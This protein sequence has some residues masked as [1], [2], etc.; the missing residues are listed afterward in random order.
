MFTTSFLGMDFTEDGR[1]V[2]LHFVE[3]E[4]IAEDYFFRTEEEATAFY[5]AC[6]RL[7]E[8]L[9]EEPV[10]TQTAIFQE[11]LD[12]NIGEFHYNRRFY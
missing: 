10:E 3:G 7:C 4:G 2:V 9:K 5:S 6:Q 12:L 1:G 8:E 11:F